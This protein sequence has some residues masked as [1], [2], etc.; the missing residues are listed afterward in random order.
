MKTAHQGH[1]LRDSDLVRRNRQNIISKLQLY[2]KVIITKGDWVLY[3]RGEGWHYGS[4]V[5][6][7]PK[8]HMLKTL[9]LMGLTNY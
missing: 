6:Y 1:D 2:R 3:G 8:P 4:N 7:L 5:K 9:F